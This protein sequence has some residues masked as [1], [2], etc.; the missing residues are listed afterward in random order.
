MI[1]RPPRSTRTD[2]LFPYTTLFRSCLR[3]FLTTAIDVERLERADGVLADAGCRR[4]PTIGPVD[5]DDL[6][7]IEGSLNVL[8]PQQCEAASHLHALPGKAGPFNFATI[9]ARL[10]RVGRIGCRRL[11]TWNKTADFPL[12]VAVGRDHVLP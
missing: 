7:L 1:R 9:P 11:N 6:R 12:N 2:T 8:C 10:A 5:T 3:N 4:K